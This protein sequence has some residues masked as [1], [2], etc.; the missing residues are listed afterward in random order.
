VDF[1]NGARPHRSK[2]EKY[3]V[4]AHQ[5]GSTGTAHV[6]LDLSTFPFEVPPFHLQ[7]RAKPPL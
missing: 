2:V 3:D 5:F 1:W 4:G 6:G 7:F